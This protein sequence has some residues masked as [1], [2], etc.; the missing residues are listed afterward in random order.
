MTHLYMFQDGDFVVTATLRDEPTQT[1]AILT[2]KNREILKNFSAPQN[3]A[4]SPLNDWMQDIR[5]LIDPLKLLRLEL[6]SPGWKCTRLIY[7]ANTDKH[8][9]T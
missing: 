1:L 6:M 5:S 7:P 4:P 3:A 9:P 8:K 2:C